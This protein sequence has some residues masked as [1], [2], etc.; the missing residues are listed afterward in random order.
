MSQLIVLGSIGNCL[1]IVDAV[2]AINAGQPED[3][4][5]LIGFLD[6]DDARQD[7]TVHGLPVLGPLSAAA[8]FPEARFVNG[9]GSPQS[10]TLKPSIIDKLQLAPERYATIV[11]PRATVS[12][13]A[14]LGPGTVLL[15][16]V[17][18]CANAMIGAHVM[19]LPNCVIGH[20]SSIGDHTI[21]AAGVS[22]SGNV[23]IGRSCYLG[24][25]ATVRDGVRIGPK[26]LLAM[27]ANLVADMPPESIYAGNPARPLRPTAESPPMKTA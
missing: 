23:Q 21:L 22:I 2:T 3:P 10:F 11:H 25:G 6:D 26:S 8:Q 9:I 14:V 5:D 7:R 19:M 16:S 27:A 24:C 15:A 4:F 18:V 17:T 13:S 1:D 12:P 20:D